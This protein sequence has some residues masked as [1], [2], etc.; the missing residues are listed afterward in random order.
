MSEAKAPKDQDLAAKAGQLK[1][2]T[3]VDKSKPVVKGEADDK[4]E[5]V[6]PG[7]KK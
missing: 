1:K 5:K 3:T 6:A 7:G 4:A 2:T